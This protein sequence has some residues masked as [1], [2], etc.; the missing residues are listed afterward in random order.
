VGERLKDRRIEIRLS[1]TAKKLCYVVCGDGGRIIY[2]SA[3][4]Y[5]EA[6]KLKKQLDDGIGSYGEPKFILKLKK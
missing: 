4:S 5:D 3:R 6:E 1:R 2:G